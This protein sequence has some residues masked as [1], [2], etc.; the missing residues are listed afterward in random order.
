MS[1]TDLRTLDGRVCET[2]K[3]A[4]QLR[5][6]LEDDEHWNKALEEEAAS[7]SPKILRNLFPAMLQTCSMS[8][9]EQ[10]WMDHKENLSED[11]LHKARIQQQNMELDYCDAIFNRALIDIEDKII[12]L[13][14][15]DLKRFGLQQPNRNHDSVLP[16]EERTE[17][18][19]DTDVLTAYIEE[20]EP[21]MVPDQKEEFDTI[22]KAVFY[23]SGGIFFWM[24]LVVQGRLFSSI[25]Y[26]LKCDKETRLPWPL[27]HLAL[28]QHY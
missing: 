21:K 16:S 13:G 3:Q 19:Y 23:S 22:T 1:F 4:C 18:N 14:G 28:P 20:N 7:R 6:L 12:L 24:L 9:T 10:L 8:S 17:R 25:V 11:I 15:S 26:W 2:Y 27:L 5:G